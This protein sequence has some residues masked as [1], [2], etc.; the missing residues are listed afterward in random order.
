MGVAGSGA[1]SWS[2]DG[3]AETWLTVLAVLL[4]VTVEGA[5]CVIV[6]GAT[7]SSSIE[8][9]FKGEEI[10]AGAEDKF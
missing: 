10:M 1:R 3:G 8:P 9:L 4:G 5:V 2:W 6:E 7:V